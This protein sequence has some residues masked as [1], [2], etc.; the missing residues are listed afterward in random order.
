MRRSVLTNA[1]VGLLTVAVVIGAFS[2]FQRK[3]S[4]FE[5]IDFQFERRNGVVVVKGVD[6]HS[7]AEAAGLRPGDQ[8]WLIA[9]TPTTEITGLQKTLR[10][11]GDTVPM[12]V[13]RGDKTVTLTYHVPVLKIDYSY[14]I[15]SFIGFLYLT[16]GLFTLFKRGETESRIFYFVTLLSF[17][18]Y[19]YTP[20]G[21]IDWSYKALQFVEEIATILL[22]PLA[23][24]FFLL[25]PRPLLRNKRAAVERDSE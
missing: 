22:P 7:G 24:H 11:F 15:L 23:L 5:R 12:I 3:R 19:V 2:S 8:I 25:F 9:D 1:A 18:V 6:P 16:I 13:S 20:A 14:L 17:I 21:D 10:R 4:S